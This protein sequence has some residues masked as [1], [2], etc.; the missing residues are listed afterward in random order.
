MEGEQYLKGIFKK[1]SFKT[2]SLG[3]LKYHE[4]E[5]AK[6]ACHEASK[7]WGGIGTLGPF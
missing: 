3:L 1:I 4:E 5:W 6:Q 7:L 2:G